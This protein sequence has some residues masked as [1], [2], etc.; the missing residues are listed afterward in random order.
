[1]KRKA[2]KLASLAI[3]A[4]LLLGALPFS[5]FASEYDSFADE[6]VLI[7]EGDS[8]DL[9][10]ADIVLNT[11]DKTGAA[12]CTAAIQAAL[13]KAFACG[14]G[15]VFLP[16]GKYRL[17]GS[18]KIPA[19]CTLRGVYF[20]PDES[21]RY[22]TVII[23][24]VP[25]VDALNPALFAIGGSAGAY[26]L[27]VYYP[28]QSI[29][30][31]LPYPCTFYVNGIT[32][33][34]VEDAMLQSVVNC[35]VINAYRGI[36]VCAEPN[37]GHE[38]FTV[39]NFKGT[40]L[41]LGA[42]A[43]N[44]SDV[45]TWKNFILSPKYWAEANTAFG[46]TKADIAKVKDYSRKNGTG[47]NLADLEWTQFV[48]LQVSD[49]KT[50]VNIVDA[51]RIEFAGIFYNAKIEN[52][53]IGMQ[54]DEIDPRWGVGIAESSISGSQYA[55]LKNYKDGY[56]KMSNVTLDGKT[57]GQG[58]VNY[59]ADLSD[60]E[61]DYGFIEHKTAM[62]FYVVDALKN[63]SAD[64]SAA[65]QSKLNEA[66]AAGGGTVY[67][68]AGRYLLK[69]PIVVPAGVELRG[70]GTVA[71]REQ[72]NCSKGTLIYADYGYVADET[73][74]DTA[75]ALIT[76][77]GDK[78]GIR[79]IRFFYPNNPYYKQASVKPCSYTIRGKGSD[80]YAINICM[81][82]TYNGIDFRDCDNHHIKKQIG[83]YYKNMMSLGGKN[84]LVEGCL[85]NG[86]IVT[87]NDFQ[88]PG[89]P[90]N[91][92]EVLFPELMNP[93]T[94]KNTEI[95][96]IYESEGQLVY[97]TFAYGVKNLVINNGGENVAL[98]NLGSDNIGDTTA[99]L[100]TAGGSLT[101]VNMMRYNGISL[102]N[103]GTDLKLYN[104]MSINVKYEPSYDGSFVSKFLNWLAPILNTL[105]K[106]FT[107]LFD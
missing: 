15:T 91:E 38:M 19:F 29:D 80:V 54:V 66:A 36:G 78:A 49:F 4:I 6:P 8:D 10:L 57:K 77:D 3:S 1:M 87:R 81:V 33:A 67:L 44:Q 22:G 70:T 92:G 23:A 37:Q 72:N 95:I 86:N 18:I 45:G 94:R 100:M 84:G 102:I 106:F 65:I 47:L 24:D 14:G 79:G 105:D 93:V 48:N 76:L 55:I 20:D 69:N 35:T 12:D 58:L 39:E 7:N 97:N 104:R 43:K 53:D 17:T 83:V 103:E 64:V 52:C 42:I 61:M 13:D 63:R 21:N 98:V 88:T 25:S 40:C 101:G 75:T 26:G 107:N 41:Y 71:T 28:N 89:W 34:H 32:A 82:G 85:N 96:R 5:A 2:L 73:V 62:R 16:E 99:Q 27:T 90:L 68:P 56:L 11:L 46:M 51:L 60:I 59:K 9:I 74:A 31:V 50:G 30:N